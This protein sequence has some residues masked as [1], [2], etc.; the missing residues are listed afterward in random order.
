M[1]WVNGPLKLFHGTTGAF[2][3]DIARG[4]IK[5][6]RCRPKS[7]FGLGFYVTPNLDQAKLHANQVF[8]RRG[9]LASQH[10]APRQSPI[11]AACI[12]FEI[13]RRDLSK[14]THLAFGGPSADWHFFVQY[15][16]VSGG[17]HVPLTKENYEVVYGPLALL[18][19]RSYPPDYEQVSFHNP[20]NFHML[21]LQRVIR[22]IP[23]L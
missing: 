6:A 2:A 12:E 10:G 7:D 20:K 18:D 8:R 22:G 15:C 14:L 16:R 4:G 17:P 5:L 9:A 23:Y 19:G 11:C 1:A 3:D 13:D 21:A